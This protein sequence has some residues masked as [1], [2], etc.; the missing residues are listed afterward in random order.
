MRAAAA[1]PPPAPAPAAPA[2]LPARLWGL[3]PL[4]WGDVRLLGAH[5]GG[6]HPSLLLPPSPEVRESALLYG[7]HPI[8]KCEVAGVV[9]RARTMGAKRVLH[10]DDGT[11]GLS[12]AAVFTTH[13][14]GS[15]SQHYLPQLGDIVV[16]AGKLGMA[17]RLGA[18][19]ATCR[20]VRVRVVRRLA[21]V[22]DLDAHVLG[23]L[24]LH[25]AR[26]ARPL[27]EW[28]PHTAG[29]DAYCA[30]VLAAMNGQGAAG[31]PAAPPPADARQ[32]MRPDGGDGGDAASEPSVW[33]L[34]LNGKVAGIVEAR[35]P[36]CGGG[37]AGGL[38]HGA[39]FPGAVSTAEADAGVGADV[40]D[41]AAAAASAVAVAV[42][43]AAAGMLPEL[44]TAVD[45]LPHVRAA[46]AAL[47][48]TRA[49]G[50]VATTGSAAA[51][52]SP[53]VASAGAADGPAATAHADAGAELHGV[54]VALQALV[55][56]GRLFVLP[57]PPSANQLAAEA[58][59]AAGSRQAAAALLSLHDR[60]GVVSL[61]RVLQPGLLACLRSGP[62]PDRRRKAGAPAGPAVWTTLQF[63]DALRGR[64]ETARVPV[65]AVARAL[66]ELLL[67]GSVCLVGP[68][69]FALDAAAGAAV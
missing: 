1:S 52:S 3:H 44:F 68:D 50:A 58:A 24:R 32:P 31:G 56:A 7:T 57:A 5:L 12:Q 4:Y 11:G 26:Y 18:L 34:W 23:T 30:P 49:Q 40:G 13:A 35:H 6:A 33:Q 45:V 27:S 60:L 64:V 28:M 9:V 38:L 20:E 41:A 36:H 37:A 16:V 22:D 25:V 46:G 62:P 55:D 51:V 19:N 14:D 65:R 2:S 10:L 61:R 42:A 8:Q 53:P 48:A 17:W 47:R 21:H 63:V 29:V 39:G 43:E 15:P 54:L 69:A 67:D 66:E 59:P